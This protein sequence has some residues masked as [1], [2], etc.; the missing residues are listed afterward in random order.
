MVK[1]VESYKAHDGRLFLSEENAIRH[2]AV[3]RLC[4]IIP[5]FQMVRPRLEGNLDAIATAMGPM[6]AFRARVPSKGPIE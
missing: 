5:E 4:A 3:E 1:K 6:L 2:E